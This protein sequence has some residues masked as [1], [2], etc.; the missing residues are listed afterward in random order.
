ML[1]FTVIHV[2]QILEEVF[3]DYWFPT[4]PQFLLSLL[5]C[6]FGPLQ[7]LTNAAIYG[8]TP[9]TRRLYA[10]RFPRACGWMRPDEA[11]LLPRGV[12]LSSTPSSLATPNRMTGAVA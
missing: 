6:L 2:P 10:E 12:E 11:K 8:W 9:R 4:T 7:G 1:A 3:W 5:N